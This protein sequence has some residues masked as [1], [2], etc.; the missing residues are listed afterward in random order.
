[1][2][3]NRFCK[4]LKNKI[5]PFILYNMQ[6]YMLLGQLVVLYISVYERRKYLK[7][8][9]NNLILNVT[10][11]DW[12]ATCVCSCDMNTSRGQ[13]HKVHE[14]NSLFS[15]QGQLCTHSWV[16]SLLGR[17]FYNSYIVNMF[18]SVFSL[19]VNDNNIF[20]CLHNIRLTY[21]KKKCVSALS[22]RMRMST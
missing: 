2:F 20:P 3:L 13:I 21:N 19:N 11:K 10:L 4:T 12:M 7:S 14:R 18:E 17:Y 16:L 1:M 5:T 15:F 22:I 8:K 6:T 9:D